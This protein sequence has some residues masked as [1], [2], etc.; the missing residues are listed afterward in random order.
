MLDLLPVLLSY[1]SAHEGRVSY[2]DA[3]SSNGCYVEYTVG[4]RIETAGHDT[5]DIIAKVR[6]F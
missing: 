2:A 1:G 3:Q 5:T 4:L 6:P